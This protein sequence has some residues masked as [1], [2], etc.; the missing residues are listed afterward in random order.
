[1]NQTISS[2]VRV[3]GLV[4]EFVE[5]RMAIR[6][7]PLLVFDHLLEKYS[8]MFPDLAVANLI[9][10]EEFRERW[11]RHFQKIGRFLSRGSLDAVG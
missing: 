7:R 1:V 11:T 10:S 2:Q 9:L 8:P 6:H 5:R 3:P 4:G